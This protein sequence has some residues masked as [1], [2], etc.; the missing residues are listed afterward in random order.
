MNSI[1][2]ESRFAGAVLRL[3][4]AVDCRQLH[5]VEVFLDDEDPR[6]VSIYVP[7]GRGHW[8]VSGF[9]LDKPSSEAEFDATP[10]IEAIEGK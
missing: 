9:D 10:W 8:A 7:D 1:D 6:H 2:E 4:L 3:L 5:D